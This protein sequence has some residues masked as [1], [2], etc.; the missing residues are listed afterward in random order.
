MISCRALLKKAREV[1][2]RDPRQ[3]YL[4]NKK[5]SPASKLTSKSPKNNIRV[6]ANQNSEIKGQEYP[7]ILN[8][9][10]I[11]IEEIQKQAAQK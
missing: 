10:T 2:P 1:D 8:Q 11:K 9:S 3:S 6:S 5:V 4:P 7:R